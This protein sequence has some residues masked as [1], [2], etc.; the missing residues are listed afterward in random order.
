VTRVT[1]ALAY[2]RGVSNGWGDSERTGRFA[3]LLAFGGAATAVVSL[4]L[5]G[6]AGEPYLEADGVNGWLVVFAAGL[7]AALIALPFG[8]EL[9]LRDR[10]PD[11]DRRWEVS[12][13][14]WGALAVVVLAIAFLAG[15]DTGTLAGAAGLI[16]AI[17]SGL[18][19]ATIAVWLLA[20]G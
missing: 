12:L 19:I 20:G 9:R 2:D 16:A 7:L 11:R 6:A 15:F 3:G 10:Y 5:A 18:V 14:L 13:L 4:V 8:L 17:E 1:P